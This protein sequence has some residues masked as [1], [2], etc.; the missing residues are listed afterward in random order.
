MKEGAQQKGRS[1][2]SE[3]YGIHFHHNGSITVSQAT[4][5]LIGQKLIKPT[6]EVVALIDASRGKNGHSGAH[7]AITKSGRQEDEF[8]RSIVS[9]RL[10]DPL[11]YRSPWD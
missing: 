8:I 5:Y 6:D 2:G 9:D 3:E 1:G 4:E 11:E 7:I 10:S